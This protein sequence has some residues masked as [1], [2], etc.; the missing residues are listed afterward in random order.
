MFGQFGSSALSALIARV[1][2]TPSPS[3]SNTIAISDDEET[4]LKLGI[5]EAL[6]GR[7]VIVGEVYGNF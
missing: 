5:S 1:K 2:W 6:R 7:S 4:N 3:V